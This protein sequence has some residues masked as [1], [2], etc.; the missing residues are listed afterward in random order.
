MRRLNLEEAARFHSR[1]HDDPHG[2]HARAHAREDDDPHASRC[3]SSV[4]V[5]AEI[6]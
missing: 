3:V 6:L 2:A 5:G 1:G 4:R